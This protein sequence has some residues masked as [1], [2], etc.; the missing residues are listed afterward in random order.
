MSEPNPPNQPYIFSCSGASDVGG[1]GDG[2]ARK[3]SSEGVAKMFC[4][5]GIGARVEQIVTNTNLAES[6]ISVD[7]CDNDCS[8]KVLEAAGFRPALHIRITDLGMEKGNTPI[9]PRHIETVTDEIRRRL[10]ESQQ[11]PPEQV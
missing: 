7:G 3:I 8:L 4:L 10:R 5:A 9:T 2:A 1:I 6:L 11:E